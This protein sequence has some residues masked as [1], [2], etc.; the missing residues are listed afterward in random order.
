MNTEKEIN[1]NEEHEEHFD[2]KDKWKKA[3]GNLRKE[4]KKSKVVAGELRSNAEQALHDL[5]NGKV[6][7][8]DHAAENFKNTLVDSLKA[9]GMTGIFLLP[10]GSVGLLALRKLLK[11]KEAK[12]LG[13][14]NLLTLT[15]EES[16]KIEE[17][18][19]RLAE[20]KEI[21]IDDIK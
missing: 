18:N 5:Q 2:L 15:V 6:F 17:E 16:R 13:V 8:D 14:E 11:S 7:T 4:L 10:G 9:A 20:D 3:K 19:K 1:T 12:K 21:G